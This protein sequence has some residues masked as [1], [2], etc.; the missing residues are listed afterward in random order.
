MSTSA[1][2]KRIAIIAGPNGAGNTTFRIKGVSIAIVF[3]QKSL[4][5]SPS[6]YLLDNTIAQR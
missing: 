6:E 4:Q 2:N 1:H 5:Q 3:K